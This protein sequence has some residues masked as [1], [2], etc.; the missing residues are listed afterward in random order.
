MA[1]IIVTT[2][3]NRMAEA[4]H[5]AEELKAA[6]GGYYYREYN[7]RRA[8][9]IEPGQRVYY[10]EDGMLRGFCVVIAWRLRRAK[11]RCDS[12]VVV[13]MYAASWKWIKPIPWKAPRSFQY[14]PGDLRD[15][16]EIVGGW[17]DPKPKAPLER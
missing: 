2:P 10:V 7:L 11:R 14:A 3:K 9:W 5:E 6:G 17:L 13:D 8:P 15:K 12:V 4:A 1:D 16:I